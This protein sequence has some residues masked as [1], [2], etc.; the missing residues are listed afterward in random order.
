MRSIYLLLAALW[1]LPVT[2]VAAQP[3]AYS[4]LVGATIDT[5]VVTMQTFRFSD[6]VRTTRVV[7]RATTRLG[8]G[9]RVQ[10][11]LTVSFKA[12]DGTT[13][14]RS[15]SADTTLGKPHTFR[16]G[17][18]IWIFKDDALI[19]LRTLA[20]GG[21]QSAVK[22]ARGDK[23]FTCTVEWNH[24]RE[25]GVGKM[26]SNSTAAGHRIEILSE[27]PVSSDCRLAMPRS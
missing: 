17:H 8:A 26:T 24:A 14:S 21:A 7:Y 3:I 9:D 20:E 22:I 11:S 13:K 23:K 16:D 15:W 1:V 10:H 4:E 25:V 6:E 12:G 27:K 5:T 18:A 2:P 19:R